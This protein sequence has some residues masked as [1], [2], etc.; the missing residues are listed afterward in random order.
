MEMTIKSKV[1]LYKTKRIYNRVCLKWM[2]SNSYRIETVVW[3]NLLTSD[4][5]WF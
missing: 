4:S 3:E 5:D 2:L 1:F